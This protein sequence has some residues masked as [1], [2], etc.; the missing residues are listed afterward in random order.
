MRPGYLW[1]LWDDWCDP[2][3]PVLAKRAGFVSLVLS[4][5]I[6]VGLLV[7]HLATGEKIGIQVVLALIPFLVMAGCCWHVGRKAWATGYIGMT[8]IVAVGLWL[9]G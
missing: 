1:Q 7:Y 4:W 9:K 5:T 3:A 8:V 2:D 6:L